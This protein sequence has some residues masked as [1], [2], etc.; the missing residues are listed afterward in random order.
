MQY[1]K[2]SFS[3][4]ASAGSGATCRTQG[5][6]MPDIRGKCVRCGEKVRV[7]DASTDHRAPPN[8]RYIVEDTTTPAP[9]AGLMTDRH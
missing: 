3:V 7:V 5:H 9:D 2:P 6:A 1:T 4:P 8:M